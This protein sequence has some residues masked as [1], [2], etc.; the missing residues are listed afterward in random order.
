MFGNSAGEVE[1]LRFGDMIYVWRDGQLRDEQGQDVPLRAKSLKMFAALLSERGKI[2]TKDRLSEVV[3]PETVATDESIARCVAD[4]RKALKDDQYKIV[5]T[6]PKKGY[7]LNVDSAGPD[8]RRTPHRGT[9][10]LYGILVMFGLLAVATIFAMSNTSAEE[11]LSA[12]TATPSNLRNTV[13]ILPF[14]EIGGNNGFLAAGLS[15][16][17][18][19][20][21]AEMSGIR[22]LSRAQTEGAS[23]DSMSPSEL[24][25]TIDSRYIVQG[26]LRRE[27]AQ[28]ALSVQLIDGIDGAT[29]WADRYEGPQDGLIEFR[30]AVPDALVEAM[31]LELSER[32]RQRLAHQDTSDPKAL[33]HVMLARRELNVFTFEGS[34][35][36]EKLL[37]NAIALDPQYARAYA[38]LASAYAIRLENDWTVLSDADTQK[39]FYFAE[40]ALD[41][42]PELWFGH[43]ALARMHSV[44]KSGDTEVA[45][46]HLRVAME[47]QPANDDARVYYAIVL[48]MS[49]GANE[50]RLILE[51]TIASHPQPPFWYHLGLAN[52]HFHLEDYETALVIIEQCLSQMPNSPYCLRTQI[53]VLARLGRIEDAE[54]TLAEYEMLGY[55]TSLDAIMKS[56]IERVPSMVAHLRKSYELA[57]LR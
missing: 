32:D 2:L 37:R 47:L 55:D 39:A 15:E 1:K 25:R 49:G 57:G 56:A 42:D 43:Y 50:S 36:A 38:E 31:S 4:I 40:R 9:V 51:S 48:M 7:R 23:S 52:A 34:L 11:E 10:P 14:I 8:A 26:S 41:L 5:Q 3:W 18:E 54:W 24:A 20:H 16:D 6:Y 21:L 19:I 30:D 53:A 35:E 13:A 29:L 28:I 46:T 44:A 12:T 27:S 45:L 17:L 33:E 22:I